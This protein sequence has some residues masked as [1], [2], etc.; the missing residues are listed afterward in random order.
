MIYQPDMEQSYELYKRAWCYTGNLRDAKFLSKAKCEEMLKRGGVLVRC[1]YDFDCSEPTNFWHVIKDSFGGMDELSSNVRNQIRR[2]QKTLD[3]RK[4]S[5]E[6]MLAQGYDVYCAA[7]EN[8][9]H[10]AIASMT[11]RECFNSDIANTDMATHD[12][13]GCIDRE[14]CTL[15]A[16]AI[17]TVAN[18]CCEYN[19]MKARPAYLKRYYPFYGLLYE[20][21]RYY[22]EE[23]GLDYVNDGARSI[24]EHSGIQD[25]LIQKFKFRKAYSRLHIVYRFPLGLLVKLAYPF[26]KWIPLELARL[27][28]RMEEF[29]R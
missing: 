19:S 16:Y 21:N 8:Y 27:L 23:C 5:V 18:R 29:S 24:T 2:A 13:W 17:N 25:F 3:I 7:W 1:C 14:S 22:L 11:T 12:F 20:M 9:K 15:V 26:R 10:T 28:L 4:I 6:E